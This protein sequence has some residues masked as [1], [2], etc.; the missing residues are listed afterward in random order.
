MPSVKPIFE[1]LLWNNCSNNCKFCFQK[2][3][4]EDLNI[5]QRKASITRVI[6]FYNSNKFI[7]DSHVLLMGGEIFD[8]P[9][10]SNELKHLFDVT[11]QMMNSRDIDL[12][13]INTNLIYKKLDSLIYLFDLIKQFKLFNRF[14]FTTSYDVIGRFCNK[15]EQLM[16]SNLKYITSKYPECHVV[17]N[18]MLSDKLCDDIISGKFSITKFKEE[19]NVDYINLIPYIVLIKDISAPRNKIFKALMTV[20]IESPGYI[21]KY[22]ENF[23]LKQDKILYKYNGNTDSLEYCSC[24]HLKCGHSENFK[25]YSD[26]NSCFICDLKSVFNDY[27]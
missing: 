13:Y 4:K 18:S 11:V 14:R 5:D 16:L 26:H 7:K 8:F 1:F 3:L 2:N 21:K 9:S 17:V 15:T 19:F 6:E 10:I 23:D 22:I 20:D 25:N 24:D 12:L 27:E